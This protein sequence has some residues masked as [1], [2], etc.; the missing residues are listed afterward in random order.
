[1][2]FLNGAQ[3]GFDGLPSSPEP[4]RKTGVIERWFRGKY[5]K[6]KICERKIDSF[7]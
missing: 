7:V 4:S 1:M 2:V 5:M 6:G 3:G